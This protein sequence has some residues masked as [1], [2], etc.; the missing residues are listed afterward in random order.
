MIPTI[1]LNDPY[2]PKYTI[3]FRDSLWVTK[4]RITEILSQFDGSNKLFDMVLSK[5][6]LYEI[7]VGDVFVLYDMFNDIYNE[8]S[9]YYKELLENY[10]KAYDYA[11]GNKRRT[12]RHDHSSNEKDG[13]RN[14]SST[15]I[16]DEYDLPNKQVNNPEGYLT[17]RNKNNISDN[18]SY[19]EANENDYDSEVSVIY[20]NEFLDLKRKYLAQIRNVYSEFAEKFNECFIKVFN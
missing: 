4:N 2:Y 20:D 12:I 7:V 13:N 17:G 10:N 15:D 3:I 16:N 19:S 5:Y 8:Y 14:S 1:R 9:Q 11:L 18:G 6:A